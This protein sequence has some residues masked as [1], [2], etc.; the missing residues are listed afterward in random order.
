MKAINKY[1][2]LILVFVVSTVMM[3][4]CGGEDAIFDSNSLLENNGFPQ[5]VIGKLSEYTKKQLISQV[6]KENNVFFDYVFLGSDVAVIIAT[7]IIRDENE[8]IKEIKVTVYYEWLSLPV[9]RRQDPIK[10]SWDEKKL[11]YKP[12][13][14]YSED[15]YSTSLSGDF[16]HM[17]RENYFSKGDGNFCWYADLRDLYFADDF[18]MISKLYGFGEI[19]LEPTEEY[20]NGDNIYIAVEYTHSAISNIRKIYLNVE[21]GACL[22]II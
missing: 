3:L 5:A 20:N 15:R 14:F 9:F 22:D 2:A 8:K 19:I 16:L 10:V 12:Q 21:Y 7:E 13:S 11:S 6:E 18:N 4:G 1:T 17:K